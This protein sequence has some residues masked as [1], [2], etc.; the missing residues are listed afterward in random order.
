MNIIKVDGR[1]TKKPELTTTPSGA[2]VTNF[3]VASDSHMKGSDGKSRV[4]YMPCTLWNKQAEA[5]VNN[6]EKG[7]RVLLS[8]SLKTSVVEKQGDTG[9]HKIKYTS[10]S[11][12]NFEFVETKAQTQ[13]RAAKA[14]A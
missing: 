9:T 3:I 13:A 10:V 12:N 8:G 6:M 7:S 11:V 5:F 2:V 1:L 4:D 14:Q